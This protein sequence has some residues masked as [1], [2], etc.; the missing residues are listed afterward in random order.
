M[1]ESGPG[2]I[3]R[4]ERFQIILIGEG[5]LAGGI[6]GLVVVL[7]RLALEQA[8]RWLT[9]ILDFVGKNPWRMA[10]WFLILALLAFLVAKLVGYEPMIA[11]SGIPQLEGELEGKL[12]QKWQKVLPAKFLGGFLGL[13][14]GLALGRAGPSIQL[15]AMAGKGVSRGLGRGK[16]EERQLLICGASAGLAAAFHAPLA[17]AM[18]SLEEF[19]K[20][21][22]ISMLI[23]VLAASLTA[24][25]VAAAA[26]G[27]EPIFQCRLIRELPLGDYWM[28]LLL[29]VL[30]GFVGAFYHWFMLKVQSFYDRAGLKGTQKLLVPFAWA[31]VLGFT[32]PVLVGGGR[33]MVEALTGGEVVLGTAVFLLLGRL[34]FSAVSF[35]SGAPGGIFFPL[36][37]LGGYIGGIFAM[38]GGQLWGLNAA[39]VNNFVLLA[40]A[41]YFTAVM[42]TPL[43]GIVLIFEMTGALDQML[44][45]SLVSVTAYITASLLQPKPISESLRDRL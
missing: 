12:D 8:G 7:Y 34:L 11:G 37:V 35:G 3:R 45:L 25:L 20:H 17:G 24:D 43:T 18:F 42:R 32:A 40:M 15:G 29:G 22:S 30:L 27:T 23:S 1:K 36:L 38:A 2:T 9:Q 4:A 44:S 19:R 5:M 33:E 21:S 10:G 41:G 28:V 13:F 6:G 14:G 16:T 26:L 31:G 39:Y